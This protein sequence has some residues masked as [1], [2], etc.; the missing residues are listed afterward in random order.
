MKENFWRQL[1]VFINENARFVLLYRQDLINQFPEKFLVKKNG[2]LMGSWSGDT[3]RRKLTVAGFLKSTNLLGV[4]KIV[5]KIP[6][7]LTKTKC[8]QLAYGKK[9]N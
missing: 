7:D 9:G 3:Y 4:Y 5:K 8:E 6:E 2:C 1:C